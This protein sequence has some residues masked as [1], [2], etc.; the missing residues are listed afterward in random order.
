MAIQTMPLDVFSSV[1]V[2]EVGLESMLS[3]A[4]LSTNDVFHAYLYLSL[5]REDRQL[6]A[7]GSMTR[8]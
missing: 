1:T 4:D 5:G 3:F 8:R 2:H 6:S 7:C